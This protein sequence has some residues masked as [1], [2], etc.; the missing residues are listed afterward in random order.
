MA[1]SQQA[2]IEI[3]DLR[4]GRNDNDP[5]LAIPEVQVL[6]ALNIDYYGDAAL[7]RKR[8]GATALATTFSSGGP[9]TGV[10]SSL[11]RHTPGADPTAAELFAVD[12]AGVVGR[13]AGAT[14]WTAPTTAD[15]FA[16]NYHEVS[17]VSLNGKLF[18]VYDSAADRLHAWDGSTIRRVGIGTAGQPSAADTGAGAISDTRTYKVAFVTVSSSVVVRRSELT[19]AT[20][21][22]TVVARQI[23]VTRPTAPGESETHWIPY[24]ASTDGVYHQLT[25][26]IAVGTTTYVDNGATIAAGE[27]PPEAG[28]HTVPTS[29]KYITTDGNRLLGAGSWESGGRNNRVWFTAVLGALD[30]GDDERV[31]N[32]L[33][34]KYWVDLDENDGDFITGLSPTL[35]GNVHV[36]KYRQFWQLEPTGDDN[37]PYRKTALSKAIGCIRG[38]SIVLAEDA[39]GNPTLYWL[40]HKGPYRYGVSGLEHLGNDIETLWGTVNLAAANGSCH[41]V[42]H[43]DKHQIWWWVATGSAAAPDVRIIY[44]TERGV[45][46]AERDVRGGWCKHTGQSASARCSVMFANT[47]GASMSRDLKPYIGQAVD[48]TIW[49]CDTS[50]TDDAGTAFQAYLTTGVRAPFGLYRKFSI[51]EALLLAK[52]ASGVTIQLTLTRDFG[53]EERTSTVT[54]TLVSVEGSATRVFRRFEDSEMAACRVIQI[55]LGDV[56][57]VSNAWTLDALALKCRPEEAS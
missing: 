8:G 35:F 50:A 34:L 45:T 52:A 11:I 13:L 20:G 5:P 38:K 1:A 51:Y 22:V 4:G 53:A 9:F 33:T 42:Y 10:V 47:V 48:N 44:D 2:L 25:S 40:S 29:W 46:T 28:L 41:G 49:K 24:G 27:A 57:A 23:T 30:V 56:S 15:T 54:L 21:S 16:A 43:A 14:T 55:T 17:G 32:T 31:P 6:E 37:L 7:A 18:L 3:R 26:P 12:S 36:F 19:V 39:A